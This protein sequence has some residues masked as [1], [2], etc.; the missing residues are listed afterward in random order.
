MSTNKSDEQMPNRE[1]NDH[2][3][4]IFVTTDIKNIVLITHIIRC[5]EIHPWPSDW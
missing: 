2:H 4:T 5:R 3:K 1:F